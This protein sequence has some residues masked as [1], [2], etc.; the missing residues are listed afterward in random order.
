MNFTSSV[1]AATKMSL[2]GGGFKG[3]ATT[4]QQVVN[5]G[6]IPY[7][8]GLMEQRKSNKH[9]MNYTPFPNSST[10]MQYLSLFLHSNF[11]QNPIILLFKMYQQEIL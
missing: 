3:P 8:I 6:K 4:T 11:Y 9:Q 5:Q 2:F 7:R 1:T 10:R